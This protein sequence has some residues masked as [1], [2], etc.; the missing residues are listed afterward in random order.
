MRISTK[1]IKPRPPIRATTFPPPE[2][3]IPTTR[4]DTTSGMTVM[5]IAFTNN[6][7]IGSTIA[8]AMRATDPSAAAIPNPTTTPAPSARRT[9]VE[10]DTRQSYATREWIGE[11][12]RSKKQEG[13]CSGAP[14]QGPS[15]HSG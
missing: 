13:P 10:R 15:L 8:I 5:R 11:V 2:V 9:L 1:T 3:A 12:V 7:P 4:L 6:V 14:G